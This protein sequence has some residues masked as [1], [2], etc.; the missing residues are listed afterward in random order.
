MPKV[1]FVKKARKDNP[2]CKKGESY[3]WWKHAYSPKRYSLT[4]PRSSQLTQ[5]DFLSQLYGAQEAI[6]DGGSSLSSLRDAIEDAR[7]VIEEIGGECTEKRDNMPDAL[8]D[9]STGEL[10]QTR[11]DS[12]EE[13]AQ[14]LDELLGEMADDDDA[15]AA[16]VIA[17]AF[18]D[19]EGGPD[20]QEIE[21]AK[22]Q[23]VSE[24]QSEALDIAGEVDEG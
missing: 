2:A 22:D 18:T 8:Q 24:W 19:K 4:R 13:V 7:S 6:E 17:T 1:T 12:C 16:R 3:Y 11:A 15:L 5:S 23:Q 21:D 20:A 14:R 9:A 10:L